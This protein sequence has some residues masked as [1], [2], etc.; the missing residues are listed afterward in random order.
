M[1]IT[2]EMIS[3]AVVDPGE[4]K[5]VVKPYVMSHGTLECRSMKETRKFY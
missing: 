4:R 3:D 1:S 2:T 5:S